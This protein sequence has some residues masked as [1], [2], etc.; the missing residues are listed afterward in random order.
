MILLAAAPP[1]LPMVR[2]FWLLVLVVIGIDALTWRGRLERMAD[3]GRIEREEGTRFLSVVIPGIALPF[4]AL[5]AI[6]AAAGWATP[7]C[8]Y[9]RPLSDPAVVTEWVLAIVWAAVVLRWVWL[10]DG[11]VLLSRVGPGLGRRPSQRTWSPRAVRWGMTAIMALFALAP[12]IERPFFIG[13]ATQ[14]AAFC[15][16]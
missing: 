4:L 9:L 8:L 13:D 15:G 10:A 14:E 2:Y 3:E 12:L 11:A 16:K 1:G 6:Q 5:F 7:L